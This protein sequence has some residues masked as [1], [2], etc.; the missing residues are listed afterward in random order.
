M[1]IKIFEE[2]L[3]SLGH[4]TNISLWEVP[5]E[6]VTNYSKE[7]CDNEANDDDNCSL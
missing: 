3:L 1:S 7:L 6:T 2:T 4:I 5:T